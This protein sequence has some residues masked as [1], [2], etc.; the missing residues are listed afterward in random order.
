M[1]KISVGTKKQ[2]DNLSKYNNKKIKII[3]KKIMVIVAHTKI[4]NIRKK[5]KTE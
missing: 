3:F 2:Q 4:Q 1:I 5:K